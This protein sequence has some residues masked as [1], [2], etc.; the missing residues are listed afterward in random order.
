MELARV[1]SMGTWAGSYQI[2]VST[3]V[4]PPLK[5]STLPQLVV[6]VVEALPVVAE[7]LETLG[8][9]V[10]DPVNGH[11]RV[12]SALD[13]LPFLTFVDPKMRDLKKHT[14]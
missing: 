14:R 6:M 9:E 1:R 13:I 11:S 8:I 4:K 3:L 7:L 10:V 12:E 5:G 2:L